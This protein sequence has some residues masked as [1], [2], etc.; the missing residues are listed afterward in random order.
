MVMPEETVVDRL[1]QDFQSLIAEIQTLD[2]SLQ[3]TLRMTLSKSLLMTVAGYFEERV[4][5]EVVGYVNKCSSGNELLEEI[6]VRKAFGRQYH[7]L[8]SWDRRNANTFFSLFG[9]R[10]SQHMKDYVDENPEYQE[11]VRAFMEIGNSRNEL[12]HG[13]YALFPLDKTVE[14]IYDSYKLGI[15]FVNSISSHLERARGASI[16]DQP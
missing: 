5:R 6:V 12:A 7:S 10:F 4:Q 16:A 1:Y 2:L 15:E 14:E 9:N 11:S 3:T 8:F 13:N